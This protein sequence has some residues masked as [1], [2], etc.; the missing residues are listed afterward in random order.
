MGPLADK[1][2]GILP[3]KNE[4]PEKRYFK[5]VVLLS[6]GIILLMI[7]AG[8]ITFFLTIQSE[9]QTMV[10]NLDGV[11]LANALIALEDRALYP[12]IQLR[13]SQD[14]A[15][16]GTV[17]GQEP[18]AGYQCKSPLKGAAQGEQRFRHRESG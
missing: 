18:V 16:K 8:L 11:E 10:P 17:V 12:A 9:E 6:V 2:Q 7:A 5:S 14:P 3:N 13:Y 1:I 15:E 4:D